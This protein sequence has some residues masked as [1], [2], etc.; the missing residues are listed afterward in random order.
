VYLKQI[1]PLC[2]EVTTEKRFQHF[3]LKQKCLPVAL[4]ASVVCNLD[5]R[6]MQSLDFTRNRFFNEIVKTSDMEIVNYCLGVSCQ[7]FC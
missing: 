5:K 6:I 2:G 7:V 4:Y 1:G 3:Y